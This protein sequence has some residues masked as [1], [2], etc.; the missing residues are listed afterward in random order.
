MPPHTK[1]NLPKRSRIGH[2]VEVVSRIPEGRELLAE[3]DNYCGWG[4]NVFDKDSA[5]QNNFNQGKQGVANWLHLEH[6]KHIE[7]GNTDEEE[8]D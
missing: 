5:A 1:K 2:L 8:T 7:K 4:R 3:I 6:E